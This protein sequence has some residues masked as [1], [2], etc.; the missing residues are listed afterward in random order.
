[1]TLRAE[2]A[3]VSRQ[4][5]TFPGQGL[6]L[7]RV[8]ELGHLRGP[9]LAKVFVMLGALTRPSNDSVSHVTYLSCGQAFQFARIVRGTDGLVDLQTFACRECGLWVTEAAEGHKPS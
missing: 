2:L 7:K 8:F 9:V 4:T 1:V 3:F 6:V 5:H